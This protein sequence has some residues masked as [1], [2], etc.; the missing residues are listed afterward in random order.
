M[1]SPLAAG[2]ALLTMLLAAAPATAQDQ[3]DLIEKKKAKLAEAWVMNA[4]WILDYDEAKA[5]AAKTK[6]PIFAYFTRSYA[7]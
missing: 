4:D 7:P 6:K 3:D 5:E 1:N 2:T